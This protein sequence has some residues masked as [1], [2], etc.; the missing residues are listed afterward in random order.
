MF[1]PEQ[2]TYT[3]Q[4][5]NGQNKKKPNQSKRAR[6]KFR[7]LVHQQLEI[8]FSNKF[9]QE[10]MKEFSISNRNAHDRDRDSR[11]MERKRTLRDMGVKERN[12]SHKTNDFDAG[13][14]NK[15]QQQYHKDQQK[16]QPFKVSNSMKQKC[17]ISF[18]LYIF[19][20][21]FVMFCF[22][23][24]TLV[25]THI[26]F[27]VE[28]RTTISL[29]CIYCFVCVCVWLETKRNKKKKWKKISFEVI[30]SSK[31]L[32]TFVIMSSQQLC[33]NVRVLSVDAL[34]F[35]YLYV[36]LFNMVVGGFFSSSEQQY[37]I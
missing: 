12:K 34:I 16:S 14:L 26:Y 36:W 10:R 22:R 29:I 15:N 17:V 5:C 31:I 21:V 6:E 8:I 13:E 37:Q 20:F 30:C 3:L 7:M 35:I 1:K 32:C 27:S 2:W 33:L 4:Y 25:G 28:Q 24:Y 11:C 18:L 19:Y 9:A 23:I